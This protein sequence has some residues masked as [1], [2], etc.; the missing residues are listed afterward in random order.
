MQKKVRDEHGILQVP[1]DSNS[2]EFLQQ[3]MLQSVGVSEGG[4]GENI[5]CECCLLHYLYLAMH[6]A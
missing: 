4:L 2:K 6:M 5:C 3:N 1:S